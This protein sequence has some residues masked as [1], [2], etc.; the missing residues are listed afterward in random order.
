QLPLIALKGDATV[1][2]GV[3][4]VRGNVV[5]EGGAVSSL[6]FVATSDGRISCLAAIHMID[7]RVRL[8]EVELDGV[9]GSVIGMSSELFE[10]ALLMNEETLQFGVRLYVLT[11]RRVSVNFVR[12]SITVDGEMR[13]EQ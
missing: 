12:L 10:E 8:Q 4:A 1:A 9:H 11:E 13:C 5:G 2:D 3:V 7:G 6:L